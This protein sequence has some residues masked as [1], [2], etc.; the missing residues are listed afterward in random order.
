MKRIEL[1][2]RIKEINFRLSK[3]TERMQKLEDDF[4]SIQCQL[5]I[6]K[7]ISQNI[8]RIDKLEKKISAFSDELYLYIDDHQQK[9]KQ[10]I[11]ETGMDLEKRVQ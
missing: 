8:D 10:Y 4:H 1:E 11:E 2:Q 9:K 5:D 3:L 6:N 7:V